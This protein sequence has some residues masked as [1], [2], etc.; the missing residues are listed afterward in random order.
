MSDG[1][2]LRLG[3]DRD[4]FSGAACGPGAGTGKFTI[5]G[6]PPVLVPTPRPVVTCRG[7]EYF[8]LPGLAALRALT[9]PA[10]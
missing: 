9:A 8:L 5:Q 3:T 10:G 6:T 2:A 1:T 4:V 7:G